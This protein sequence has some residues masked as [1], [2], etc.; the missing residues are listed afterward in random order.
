M[1]GLSW[2]H[3]IKGGKIKCQKLHIDT[4]IRSN[5]RLKVFEQQTI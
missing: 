4:L 3:N 2:V 1:G 5:M